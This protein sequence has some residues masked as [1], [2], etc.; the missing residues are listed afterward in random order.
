MAQRTQSS[1]SE[2]DRVVE[3]WAQIASRRFAKDA[4]VSTNPG[5]QRRAQLGFADELRFPDVLVWRSDSADGRDGT[6]E[7]VA[8]VETVDSL[9]DEEALEWAAYGRVP[10]PFHLVVPVGAEEEAIRLVRKKAARVSQLWS[11]QLVG[12][13][14][15]FSQY[16]ELPS[17]DQG[18]VVRQE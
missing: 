14:V 12:G 8:E 1:Q 11:Y 16:L 9:D 3:A 5:N 2:H 17:L 4:Q 7:L 6:A 15:I 18:R 10:A 13:E